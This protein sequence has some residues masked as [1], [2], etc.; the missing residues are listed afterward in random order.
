MAAHKG[1]AK[2]TPRDVLEIRRLRGEGWTIASLARA[3]KMSG[4]QVAKICD[5]T[6]WAHISQGIEVTTDSD[7]QLRELTT[8]EPSQDEIHRSL[9]RLQGMLGGEGGN[10]GDRVAAEREELT[11]EARNPYELSDEDFAAQI[12]KAKLH[13]EANEAAL[14]RER[15]LNAARTRIVLPPPTND[16]T[17]IVANAQREDAA[18]N[19]EQLLETLKNETQSLQHAQ[20][21]VE[22]SSV[23][24][25]RGSGDEP[26]SDEQRQLD[27]AEKDSQR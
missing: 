11:R 23:G 18:I 21:G 25:P 14:A 1:N 19:A 6:A 13:R 12:A 17:S 20:T 10:A 27:A 16:S 4:N 9:Q 26:A 22:R 5:G 3:W 2:L 7:A 15:E 8:P 24:G